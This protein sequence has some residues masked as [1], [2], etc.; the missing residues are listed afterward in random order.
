MRSGFILCVYL[1]ASASVCFSQTTRAVKIQWP[2]AV[3][4]ISKDCS[5]KSN[6]LSVFL[7]GK[8]RAVAKIAADYRS[9]SVRKVLLSINQAYAEKKETQR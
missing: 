8:T 6:A 4:F 1:I 9:V 5:L 2:Q 7:T 3:A